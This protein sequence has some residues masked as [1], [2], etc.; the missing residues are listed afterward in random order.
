MNVRQEVVELLFDVVCDLFEVIEEDYKTLLRKRFDD[1]DETKNEIIYWSK[2]ARTL[3][4]QGIDELEQKILKEL[5]KEE[6]SE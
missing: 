6:V 3:F 5:E 2:K 1:E 4:Y